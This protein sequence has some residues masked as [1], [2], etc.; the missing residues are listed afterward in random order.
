ML[1]YDCEIIKAIAKKRE[2]RL[3]GIEYCDGWRDFEGMGISVICAMDVDARRVR[4]FCKDNFD[5]FQKLVDDHDAIIGFN[6]IAFDNRLCEA[7]GINVPDHRSYDILIEVWRAA[8]LGPEFK[9]PS[10]AGFGL[11][12]LCKENFG[13]TKSGNGALAPVDWQRGDIGKVID[14]CL[15]DVGLTY[16]LLAKINRGEIL[17]NPKGGAFLKCRSI[18]EAMPSLHVRPGGD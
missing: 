9:Y 2:Q 13:L 15:N 16:K 1:I 5:E 8:G 10:H 12:A 11:E 18:T 6:S 7:N 17:R 4:V 3:E 14:Y